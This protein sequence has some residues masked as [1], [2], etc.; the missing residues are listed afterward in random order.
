MSSI[1]FLT[2]LQYYYICRNLAFICS[3][4]RNGGKHFGK[5]T[6]KYGNNRKFS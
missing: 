6:K 3:I 5:F 4:S 2:L 1:D